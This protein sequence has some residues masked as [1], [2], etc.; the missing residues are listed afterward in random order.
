MI[1]LKSALLITKGMP[2]TLLIALAK[3]MSQPWIWPLAGSTNS[4]GA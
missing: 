3:S 2:S 4:F 1:V